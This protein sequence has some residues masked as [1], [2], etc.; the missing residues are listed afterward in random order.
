MKVEVFEKGILRLIGVA[1]KTTVEKS[2]E[3]VGK[4]MMEIEQSNFMER[5][6]NRVDPNTFYG[7]SIDFDKKSGVCSY[8]FGA[9]VTSFADIPDDMETRIIPATKYARILINPMDSELVE[10][11]KVENAEDMG[12]LC[13]GLFAYL[14]EKWIPES[15]YSRADISEVFEE[16][17]ITKMAEGFYIY[18]PIK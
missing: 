4:F 18:V 13:G 16:Y 17:N 7:I 3:D 9:E 5:I 10:T 11:A 12:A 6:P 8:M 2:P 14:K 1:L 15:G